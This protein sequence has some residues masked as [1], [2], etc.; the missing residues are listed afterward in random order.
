M[1]EAGFYSRHPD[2]SVS[3]HLCRHRCLIS[4][5]KRGICRVRE[6]RHGSLYSLVYGQLVSE[7]I[8]PIEK[9]PLYHVLPGSQTYSI[10]SVGC[11]FRCRHCQNHSIAQFEPGPESGVPGRPTDPLQIV[12]RALES[13]CR[14]ISYTYTEPTVWGEY[15]CDVA[16]LASDAG[17]FNIMVTNGYVTPEALDQMAPYINAANIDLKG[18]SES[19]YLNVA[20]ARLGEVLDCLRDFRRRGIWIEVTTLVIPQENDDHVQLAGC[21]GFIAGELGRDVPWHISRFFPQYRMCDRP[22]TDSRALALVYHVG[23]AAGLRFVYV[24][25]M[26]G[27]S[28]STE[29]PGCGRLLVERNGFCSRPVGLTGARCSACGYAVPG[30][31]E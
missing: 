4:S 15:V 6:N 10:A 12:Q 3:C 13:G 18:F 5:G 7:Q 9:K 20:S 27:E 17:L 1:R 31:W 2:G 30:L 23:K 26:A 24:G 25:N 19:F 21:A 16:R 29:C 22:A 28:Q 14:S 11:N 8:D